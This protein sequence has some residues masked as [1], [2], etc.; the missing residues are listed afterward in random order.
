MKL[1]PG[2]H[3]DALIARRLWRA[4]V[5]FDVEGQGAHLVKEGEHTPVPL[6]PYSTNVDEAH[7]VVQHMQSKGYV[8]RLKSA[9]DIGKCFACFYRNDG[10]NYRMSEGQTLSMAICM[11]ALEAL[12]G[13]HIV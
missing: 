6:P 13:T 2:P 9:P 5:V 7:R 12:D 3:T 4:I 8:A 11:A 10:R 1:T